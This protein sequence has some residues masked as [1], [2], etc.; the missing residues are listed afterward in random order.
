MPG[1]RERSVDFVAIGRGGDA[2]Q[3]GVVQ[4]TGRDVNTPDSHNSAVLRHAH[5]RVVAAIGDVNIGTPIEGRVARPIDIVRVSLVGARSTGK[6]SAG[7]LMR[8][9][10]PSPKT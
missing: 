4:L 6:F 1:P 7:E 3:A 8:M 10:E 9:T 2:V 5:D